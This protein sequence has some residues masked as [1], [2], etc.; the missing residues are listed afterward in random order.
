MLRPGR[1]LPHLPKRPAGG[2]RVTLIAAWRCAGGIVIHADAQETVGHY[3]RAVQKLTPESMGN[4]LVTVAGSGDS[5]LVESLIIR[6]RRRVQA[7]I[8]TDLDGFVQ[9]VEDEVA[10]FYNVDVACYPGENKEVKFVLGAVSDRGEYDLWVSEHI[11]LRKASKYELVGWDEPLYHNLASRLY[12]PDLPMS[13]A[14]LAGL[15]LMNVA[16]QTSN[17]VKGP[18]TA[19]ILGPTGIW[20]T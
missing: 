12:R 15:Y 4:F 16:E 9:E 17:Y 14:I 10:S 5:P 2:K 6:L 19:I 11:R 18:I 3:R 8:A 1:R 13:Q 7:S 20:R